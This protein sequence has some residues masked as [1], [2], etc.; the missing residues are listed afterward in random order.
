MLEQALPAARMQ[1]MQAIHAILICLSMMQ[2]WVRACQRFPSAVAA[3]VIS[4]FGIWPDQMPDGSKWQELRTSQHGMP[5]TA[6]AVPQHT[7]HQWAPHSAAVVRVTV[8]EEGMGD[9]DAGDNLRTQWR[10]SSEADLYNNEGIL[11]LGAAP[12]MQS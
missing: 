3:R 1:F 2:T 4:L 8:G 6:W 10:Q 12:S 7:A 9:H 5:S 11:E